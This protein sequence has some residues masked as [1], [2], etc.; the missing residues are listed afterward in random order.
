M[1]LF[2]MRIADTTSGVKLPE[3]LKIVMLEDNVTAT[4]ELEP[5]IRGGK[6]WLTVW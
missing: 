6:I 5:D 4:F 3:G 2:H 1:P